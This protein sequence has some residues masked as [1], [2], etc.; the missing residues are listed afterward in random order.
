[1][2]ADPPSMSTIPDPAEQPPDESPG[3]PTPQ[4]DMFGRGPSTVAED[5]GGRRTVQLKSY[6]SLERLRDRILLASREMGR[7]RAENA[8]LRRQVEELK[9]GGGPVDGTPIVFTESP[10]ALRAKV[11]GFIEAVDQYLQDDFADE[12]RGRGSVD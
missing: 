8:E 4:Q 7:L 6:K 12:L 2:V 9:A 3:E 5:V 1:M 10:A 11:E